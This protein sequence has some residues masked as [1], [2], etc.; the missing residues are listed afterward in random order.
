MVPEFHQNVSKLISELASEFLFRGKFNITKDP[1]VNKSN[2]I[3]SKRVANILVGN[4]DVRFIIKIHYNESI[5]KNLI[6]KYSG[7]ENP[8]EQKIDDLFK[9]CCNLLAG[10]LKK[11]F[12]DNNFNIGIS[13][14]V[15]TR[16]ID[17]FFF[18]RK[19]SDD[20]S[21]ELTWEMSNGEQSFFMAVF[22]EVI[23]S[24][25]IKQLDFDKVFSKNQDEDEVEF[26]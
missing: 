9:E 5:G 21:H 1:Y 18:D 26:F 15:K 19:D 24:T 16:G 6:Q 7:I 17:E 25:L 23:N 11:I 14:P 4:P 10:R 8:S 3:L 2:V 13:I 12:E 20:F 22:I